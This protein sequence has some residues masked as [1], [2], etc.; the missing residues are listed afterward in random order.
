MPFAIA[1]RSKVV[2]SRNERSRPRA[3]Y[4][5]NGRPAPSCFASTARMDW[6]PTATKSDELSPGV[7]AIAARMSSIGAAAPVPAR[8]SKPPP[9]LSTSWK[10]WTNE[11]DVTVP[12]TSVKTTRV[13]I[14]SVV[15]VRKRLVSGYAIAMRST[16]ASAW[17]RPS[18]PITAPRSTS[19]LYI[20]T[21]TAPI[22]T[23]RPAAIQVEKFIVSWPNT[24]SQALHGSIQSTTTTSPTLVKATRSGTRSARRIGTRLISTSDTPTMEPGRGAA[25]CPAYR[26][27][28]AEPEAETAEEPLPTALRRGRLGHVPDRSRDRH[29][30]DAPGRDGHHGEREENANGECDQEAPGRD[31][32]FD[33]QSGVGVRRAERVGHHNDHSVGHGC[34]EKGSHE[35][36]GEVVAKPL[37]DEHLD[38]VSAAR[39]DRAGDPELAAALGGE[40]HE[41]EEDKEDA[42]CNRE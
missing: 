23:I 42:R 18:E 24:A 32:I 39:T 14:A 33:L 20:I 30:A 19:A 31:R 17:T 16:G 2:W 7:L 13:N 35:R 8:T 25:H 40:H 10:E 3:T 12:V 9:D 21:Q 41:D 27:E 26:E 5:S 4:V 11:P 38:D 34:A 15:P 29:H 6:L 28:Q 22:T 1:P 37:E 36:G